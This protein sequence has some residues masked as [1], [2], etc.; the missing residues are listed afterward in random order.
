MPFRTVGKLSLNS[1]SN[2]VK[3]CRGHRGRR[4]GF[5]LHC[6]SCLVLE[7]AHVDDGLQLDTK[8][9]NDAGSTP[10]IS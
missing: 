2:I 1:P 8:E 10:N 6:G 9:K 7:L 3:V 5:F 4:L